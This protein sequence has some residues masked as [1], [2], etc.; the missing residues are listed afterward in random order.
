MG[1]QGLEG[2]RGGAKQG[3]RV[4]GGLGTRG[5]WGLGVTRCHRG[6]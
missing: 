6:A 4:S 3:Y 2:A 5:G 1:P